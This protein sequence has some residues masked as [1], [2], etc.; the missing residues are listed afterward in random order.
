[1]DPD[2]TLQAA[3]LGLSLLP[4]LP[5]W[6]VEPLRGHES[7]HRA[8]SS[9]P[10]CRCRFLLH[11]ATGAEGQAVSDS[12][13]S[14]MPRTPAFPPHPAGRASL[15]LTGWTPG[16]RL[17]DRGE[18]GRCILGGS[19]DQ[20]LERGRE[21][22]G[23]GRGRSWA[24]MHL[25]EDLGLRSLNA[26]SE[27]SSVASKRP[28]LSVPSLASHCVQTVPPGVMALVQVASLSQG[29]S[30]AADSHG[31]CANSVPAAGA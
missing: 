23:L 6:A 14:S 2:E 18:R 11:W 9:G 3:W 28:G 22:A 5:T 15:L 16:H 21:E 1:M 29:S 26:F 7:K 30:Q 4:V 8:T 13:L 17:G 24:V 20:R 31:L 12:P 25:N 27:S 10:G 19:R